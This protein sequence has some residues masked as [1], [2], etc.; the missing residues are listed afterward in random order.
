MGIE[1]SGHCAVSLGPPLNYS[2][3][4]PTVLGVAVRTANDDWVRSQHQFVASTRPLFAADPAVIAVVTHLGATSTKAPRIVCSARGTA[5]ATVAA[6]F[7][8]VGQG[9]RLYH[10][11]HISRH[12]AH[13]RPR[14]RWGDLLDQTNQSVTGRHRGASCYV[15]SHPWPLA[16]NIRQKRTVSRA[17]FHNVRDLND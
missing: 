7:F 13:C 10:D 9:V 12:N 3:T 17:H 4:D 6:R 2:V 8:L 16:S 15:P 1:Y 5:T 11:T 14:P